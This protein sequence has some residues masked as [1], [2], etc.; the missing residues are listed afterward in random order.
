MQRSDQT[1]SEPS[2]VE[3]QGTRSKAP[4][5]RLVG[6]PKFE[7]RNPKQFFNSPNSNYQNLQTKFHLSR[8]GH[9]NIRILELFRASDLG[10]RIYAGSIDGLI[11]KTEPE[12]W[13]ENR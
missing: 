10:F 1:F 7:Y 5:S 11:H 13:E 9:L 6:N 3:H 12:N 8:F 4:A 2:D